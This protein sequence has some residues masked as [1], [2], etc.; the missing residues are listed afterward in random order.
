[1]G[2]EDFDFDDLPDNGAIDHALET[3]QS[4]A[5]ALVPADDPQRAHKAIRLLLG[6]VE[7]LAPDTEREISTLR[8]AAIQMR[9]AADLAESHA[10]VGETLRRYT[11]KIWSLPS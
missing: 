3:L 6:A 10:A 11:A 8:A 4:A 2:I 5:L 9:A 7:C 1:M